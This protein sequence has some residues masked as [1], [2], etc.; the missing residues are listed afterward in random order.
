MDISPH[1]HTILFLRVI[2][3]SVLSQIIIKIYTENK[4]LS[5]FPVFRPN[6][7]TQAPFLQNKLALLARLG[8]FPVMDTAIVRQ[9][10]TLTIII[11]LKFES[12]VWCWGFSGYYL[13]LGCV[14]WY[15]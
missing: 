2:Q 8:G 4:W 10:A 11:I 14:Y 15:I 1:P 9:M 13:Y 12:I 3:N 7:Q 5:K 6:Y